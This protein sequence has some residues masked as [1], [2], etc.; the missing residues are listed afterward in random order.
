MPCVR[1]SPRGEGTDLALERELAGWSGELWMVGDAVAP[2]TCEEAVL[3]GLKVGSALGG[4]ELAP[5]DMPLRM[6]RGGED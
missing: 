6:G 1:P 3:E 4:G 2:R 5:G